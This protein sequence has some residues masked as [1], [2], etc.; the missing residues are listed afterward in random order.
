MKI[1]FSFFITN[2]RP[3][4]V[5]FLLAVLLWIA[6]ATNKT[7]TTRVTVP[8][9]I[10][11]IGE[12]KVLMDPPPDKIV[13]EVTGKGRALIALNFYKGKIRLDLPE[14]NK[15]TT[16]HLVNYLNRFV[17]AR[18]LGI[19][20]TDVIEPKNIRLKVDEYL[21]AKRPIKFAGTIRPLAGY[22]L[23]REQLIPDSVLVKGPASFIRP[24]R[25]I[26]T[27][28]IFKKKVRYPFKTRL[29][30]ISPRPDV[31]QLWPQIAEI[32][33]QI[34]Q[35]VERTLYEVPI[36]LV[37][38]PTKYLASAVPEKVSVKIKGAE[39]L[40][41]HLKPQ[42]V[43]ALYNFQNSYRPGVMVYPIEVDAPRGISVV[44]TIPRTF[45]LQLKQRED[46]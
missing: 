25:Y 42:E 23:L 15:T 36:Q 21:E 11:R 44:N 16:L 28:S 43:T 4:L 3:L 9:Q 2:R 33:F 19:K 37:G 38:I 24:I 34:E 32:H 20:V 29:K 17:I 6:I 12:N 27:D 8:F 46:Y 30:L 18:E 26:K 10:V 5:S 39:S 31:L 41:T 7:Y 13:L 35:I 45:H 1:S 22:I 40:V 14:V